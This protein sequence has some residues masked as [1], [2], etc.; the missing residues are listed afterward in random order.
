MPASRGREDTSLRRARQRIAP[1]ALAAFA[2]A[3]GATVAA[4]PPPR[5]SRLEGFASIDRRHKVVGATVLIERDGD[6]STRWL[7]STAEH[8]AFG[9]DG[10]PDGRYRVELTRYGLAPVVKDD[11]TL[12]F[13]YRAI[14]EVTMQEEAA[15]AAPG[16]PPIPSP[17]AGDTLVLA[18]RVM[19]GAGA[20]VPETPLR[21]LR[22]D[23]TL[24][25]RVTRSGLDGRFALDGLVAGAWRV[26]I[27]G[28]GF[29]P[30]VRTME[31][32]ADTELRVRLARQPADYH[33]TPL[34]LM[35]AEHP[36]PPRGQQP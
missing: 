33:P 14:V 32:E 17:A 29:L 25:P 1:S 18:G 30:I 22:V 31:L 9:V 13:P 3:A 35:P 34:E 36:V 19:D 21:L 5:T 20:P 6:L 15:P 28:V 24:D 12:R 10:L 7:T 11:V 16:A 2:L 27:R 23:G 8:G 4:E 26:E